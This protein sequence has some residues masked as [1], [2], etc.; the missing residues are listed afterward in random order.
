M[1]HKAKIL[2]I[3]AGG[4]MTDTFIIDEKGEFIVGKAQTTPHDESIG[5]ANSSRDALKY[6][7][8][9]PEE[10]FPTIISGIYSGT[11][12]LNRLLE[13]KGKR[14]G[15]IVTAG[16][17]DYLRLERGIQTYLGY[18]YSDRLH[19]ATHRHNEPLIPR[20]RIRGVRERIDLFGDVI[21]PLYEDEVFQAVEELLDQEVEGI[22]VNLLYSYRNPIHEVKVREIAEKVMEK[23]GV[24]VPLFLASELYP[25]RRDFPRL[26]TLLVEAYAAEPSRGQLERVQNKVNELGGRFNIRV[27]A[28]H[29]GTIGIDAK[30]LAPTL[31]S[32]PIGGVI[33][34]KYLAEKL[35]IKNVVCTDIGG[36]SFDLAL[37]TDGEFHIKSTPDIARFILNLPLV[38]IDSVG[39]GTGTFVRVNPTSNRIELGPDSAGYRI[40]VSNEQ[41]NLDAPT[42]SDCNL[43]LGLLN[44][45]FFLGGDI[46]LNKQRAI[47]VIDEKIAKPLGLNVYD[48]ASGVVRLFEDSLKNQVVA[49]VLGKGY[50]P[51]NYTLLCYGGGGP[52]HVGGCT[53]GLDFEDVI[54]PTWAAGFSAFG[55]A[56]ADFEYRYDRTVDL[57]IGGIGQLDP[58]TVSV[59]LNAAWAELRQ[60]VI[61]QFEKSGI[62][63][64]QIKF[65]HAVRMQYQGQLNDLEFYTRTGEITKKEELD[66]IVEEFE[67]LYGRIYARSA[68]SPELGYLVTT[69]IVTG[70]VPVEKPDLPNEPLAGPEPPAEA[71]KGTREVY[72]RGNWITADIYDMEKVKPG[73]VLKGLSIVEAPATT[74]VV[75]PDQEACL[76][77]YRIFHLR[78]KVNKFDIGGI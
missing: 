3:D 55:C 44:P 41:E 69:A 4:T 72:W 73:N 17:E 22:C 37:I 75:P 9:L 19:V 18:S 33:G 13:R 11:A 14:L 71:H 32:G 24:Q 65:R 26:N 35:G 25:V 15:L 20:E 16:Q 57:P 61:S 54:I 77:Q 46:K 6:W 12:M 23:K 66:E 52:L 2:A 31:V 48:A 29:G 40:G 10:A 67:N 56:C 7:G 49:M 50:A 34:G 62:P 59:L 76:D 39:A 30:K 43:V 53:E 21:I 36:T 5:V 58:M 47:E 27:M 45:D 38:Q 60:K 63:E 42:I 64:D 74:F 1:P 78:K 28:S 70:T 51:V 68:K 8:M